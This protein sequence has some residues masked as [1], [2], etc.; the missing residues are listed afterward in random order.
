[1]SRLFRAAA[2]MF[3]TVAAAFSQDG[4]LPYVDISSAQEEVARIEEENRERDAAND[5]FA[6]D[7]ETLRE[8]IRQTRL[9]LVEV[10][11]M[12][13]RVSVQ[14]TELYEVNATI[15]DEEMQQRSRAVIGRARTIKR[16]LQEQVE[17]L[18]DQI[19]AHQDQI[20]AHQRRIRIN[21]SRTARGEER[22]IFLEAAVEHTEAQRRRLDRFITTVDSILS[23]AEQY[24]DLDE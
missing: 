21:T 6:G 13:D 3:F 22:I 5:A 14:L 2:V 1:M 4:D 11:P 9:A 17:S 10:R 18:Y 20:A 19:D 16:R 7:I 24:I 15:V 12:L 23:E 8:E